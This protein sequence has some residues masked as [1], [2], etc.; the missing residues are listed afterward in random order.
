MAG[1][2][3]AFATVLTPDDVLTDDDEV[4]GIDIVPSSYANANAKVA[5]A[6]ANDIYRW[7]DNKKSIEMNES[8]SQSSRISRIKS[9]NTIL[10]LI[11]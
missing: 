7:Q 3:G 9:I 1:T 2:L 11:V 6:V 10:T 4:S 5:A 8:V